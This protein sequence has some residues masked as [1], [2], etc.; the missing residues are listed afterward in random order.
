MAPRVGSSNLGLSSFF[1]GDLA[2]RLNYEMRNVPCE[3][4][5]NGSTTRRGDLTKIVTKNGPRRHGEQKKFE[6][7]MMQYDEGR[8]FGCKSLIKWSTPSM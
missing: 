7:G 4:V 5:K 6:S 2:K 3:D 8:W 1:R